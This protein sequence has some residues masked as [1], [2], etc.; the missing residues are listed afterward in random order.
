MERRRRYVRINTE[1]DEL[2]QDIDLF[3]EEADRLNEKLA[4]DGSDFRWMPYGAEE[5]AAAA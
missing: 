3:A 2:F 1:T 5:E 4:A